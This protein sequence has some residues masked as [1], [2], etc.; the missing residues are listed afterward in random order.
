MITKLLGGY[1]YPAIAVAILL[2]AVLVYG[3]GHSNASA[4]WEAKYAKREVE[5]AQQATAEMS[6]MSQANAMAKVVEAK[7]LAELAADNA[8][9]ESKIKELSDEADADPDR[10]RVCLSDGG[11]V[12]IDAVH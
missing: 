1:L 8:V 4:S 9:L 3:W 7:R 12:R 5:M 2:A 10:D 6:R 11:R